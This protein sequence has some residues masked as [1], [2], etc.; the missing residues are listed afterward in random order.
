MS[1]PP[2]LP[3]EIRAMVYRHVAHGAR[4][5]FRPNRPLSTCG[6]LLVSCKTIR[7][8]FLPIFYE[9]VRIDFS[10]R[11]DNN[12][13][14]VQLPNIELGDLRHVKLSE[15]VF[16]G[17]GGMILLRRISSLKSFTFACNVECYLPGCMGDAAGCVNGSCEVCLSGLETYPYHSSGDLGGNAM[18]VLKEAVEFRKSY[19]L[20]SCGCHYSHNLDPI[21]CPG[22]N[23]RRKVI[24][25]WQYMGKPFKLSAEVWFIVD[26]SAPLTSLFGMFDLETKTMVVRSAANPDEILG[27]F[28]VDLE[29]F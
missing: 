8:E 28:T 13:G 12:T 26:G 29:D 3:P 25:A 19:L 20:G 23:P 2:T 24:G 16:A 9:E 18:E 14:A 27:Q 17:S 22:G 11:I 5:I 4:V 6:A 21:D 10:A 15:N 1:G 7:D